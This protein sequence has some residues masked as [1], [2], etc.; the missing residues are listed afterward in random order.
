MVVFVFYAFDRTPDVNVLGWLAS[1]MLRYH[2]EH[3]QH[4]LKM[5]LKIKPKPL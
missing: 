1:S 2:I 4:L 5:A 3:G